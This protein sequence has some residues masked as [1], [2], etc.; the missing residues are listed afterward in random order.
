MDDVEQID[1]EVAWATTARQVLL[2][3]RLPAGVTA[4]EAVRVSGILEQCPDIDA[5][6]LVLGVFGVRIGPDDAV[7]A[8]DRI[9]I[10]RP[11]EVD[12]REARRLLAARGLPIGARR[13]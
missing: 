11:L 12:P 9:E 2:G 13:R 6:H 8:G 3:I 1:V 10:Y 5:D 4:I 7:H